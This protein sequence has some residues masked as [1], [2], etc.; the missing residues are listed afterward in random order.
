MKNYFNQETMDKVVEK[1]RLVKDSVEGK[2]SKTHIKVA[3][4]LSVASLGVIGVCQLLP[5]REESYEVNP[6][7]ANYA[8]QVESIE[9]I[10]FQPFVED[11]MNELQNV[12]L[13]AQTYQESEATLVQIK[14]YEKLVNDYSLI[15]RSALNTL[16]CS[17]AK[18]HGGNFLDYNIHLEK[19]DGTWIASNQ[20]IGA[21]DLT[22]DERE[23]ASRIGDLQ[24]FRSVNLYDLSESKMDEYV[25]SCLKV[26]KASLS[27]AVEN[28]GE[29][30]K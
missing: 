16:K 12:V 2:V 20:E 17:V 7:Y 9:E 25:A 4:T 19:S 21:I 30:K 3:V 13:I 26:S 24:D 5:I 1:Y 22:G 27:L 10:K 8:Q 23:L 18:K 15:Q 28:L 14:A 29:K 6:N 11:Q